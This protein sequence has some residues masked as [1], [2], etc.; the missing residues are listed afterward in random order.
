MIILGHG[1]DVVELES[2]AQLVNAADGDFLIRCFTAAERQSVQGSVDY[3]QSLAGKFAAKE[4]VAKALGTGFDSEVAP[5][6]IEIL[7][8]GNGQPYVCLHSEAAECARIQGVSNWTVSISHSR[9]VAIASVIAI[10]I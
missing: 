8:G 6:E 1:V 2:F 10:G 9:S 5:I 3:I 7:V 4:A